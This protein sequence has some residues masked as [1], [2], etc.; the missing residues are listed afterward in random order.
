MDGIIL[1][2]TTLKTQKG[3]EYCRALVGFEQTRR[4]VN[5]WDIS[6]LKINSVY[7]FPNSMQE[8]NDM[9][10]VD[11]KSLV[12]VENDTLT[13]QYG[14]ILPTKESWDLLIDT[15]SERFFNSSPELALFKN[16]ADIFY[17]LYSKAPASKTVHHN[18]SGGLLVHT[19][20]ML[21]ILKNLHNPYLNFKHNVVATAVLFHDYGKLKCYKES[22][23][24]G[25]DYTQSQFLTNHIYLSASKFDLELA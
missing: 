9:L 10:S 11:F 15:L 2:S 12:E 17:D 16:S 23:E 14:H 22:G 5:I 7:Q 20:Q 1:Q 25:F 13:S 8:Y 19:F 4:I 24:S 18:F 3:S 6:K 21:S